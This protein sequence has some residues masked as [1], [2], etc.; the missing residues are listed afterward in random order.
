MKIK[1]FR[2]TKERRSFDQT[3]ECNMFFHQA[4]KLHSFS[5]TRFAKVNFILKLLETFIETET[6]SLSGCVSP[7][8]GRSDSYVYYSRFTLPGYLKV[9]YQNVFDPR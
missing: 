6:K 1:K 8:S 2:R 3:E 7:I 9:F 4:M 5:R